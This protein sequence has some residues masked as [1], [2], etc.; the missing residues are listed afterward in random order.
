M[1][2]RIGLTGGIAAGKSAVAQRLQELGAAIIDYDELS[3]QVVLPGSQA[4][5]H[6]VMEFGAQA[7]DT[8]GGLNRSWMASEVFAPGHEKERQ[9]LESII[10]PAVFREALSFD[11]QFQR[12]MGEQG[13]AYL[14]VHE[15]PLL[16]EV[17][18]NIPFSFEHVISVEAP[19]DERVRRMLKTRHMSQRDAV[20]RVRSQSSQYDRRQVAD[21]IIDSSQ[22]FEQMFDMVDRVYEQLIAEDATTDVG[23]V[24][25]TK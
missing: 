22:S 11:K 1:S 9:K 17:A 21:I 14:I 5:Q 15:I 13:K 6:I 16:A 23:R 3:H 10:H 7:L 8:K 2:M 18:E 25:G 19:V 20:N 24:S 4:L 12:Q